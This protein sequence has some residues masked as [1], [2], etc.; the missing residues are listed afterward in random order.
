MRGPPS[1]TDTEGQLGYTPI[2]EGLTGYRK[3]YYKNRERLVQQQR[4]RSA[5]L[6]QTPEYKE[7]K[8]VYNERYRGTSL[9][10]T[11]MVD[12]YHRNK[13]RI[14]EQRR[15][16]YQRVSVEEQERRR[17]QRGRAASAGQTGVAAG[18]AT[19]ERQTKID[20]PHGPEA[21]GAGGGRRADRD[22]AAALPAQRDHQPDDHAKAMATHCKRRHPASASCF[23]RF[24]KCWNSCGSSPC[25]CPR[26][27]TRTRT[28][29]CRYAIHLSH[30]RTRCI[31]IY[32]SS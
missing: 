2:L 13:E 17:L 7:Q 25:A 5:A 9:A 10:A 26:S 22:R 1:T 6:K 16:N 19:G 29:C 30:T 24:L 4:E 15:R 28:W 21:R 27:R 12:Y 32:N 23:I 11:Y 18:A 14:L 20:H 3:Y 8:R 31:V